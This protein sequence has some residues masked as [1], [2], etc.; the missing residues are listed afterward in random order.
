MNGY[1]FKKEL[2][3]NILFGFLKDTENL[4]KQELDRVEYSKALQEYRSI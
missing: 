4:D 3:M 2:L 1:R